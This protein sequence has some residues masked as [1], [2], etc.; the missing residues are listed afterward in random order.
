MDFETRTQVLAVV[1]Q[2]LLTTKSPLQPPWLVP[3]VN[4]T[5]LDSPM[6]RVS[7]TAKGWAVVVNTFNPSTWEAETDRSL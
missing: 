3:I 6:K 5:N 4:L 2:V 7:M 1:Q